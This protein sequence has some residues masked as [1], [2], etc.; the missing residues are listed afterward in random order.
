MKKTLLI[1]ACGVLALASIGC[2]SSTPMTERQEYYVGRSM[3]AETVNTTKVVT[4]RNVH[5]Y[6]NL[7][8]WNLAR[9]TDRPRTFKDYTVAV[10]KTN[11][12]N[13]Y[14]APSGFIF[15]TTGLILACETED[16][17]AAVMAHEI[18]H[19]VNKHPEK[20]VQT[21]KDREENAKGALSLLSTVGSAV[22]SAKGQSAEDIEF[23][24]Q[25]LDTVIDEVLTQIKHGYD[26]GQ[27]L[28][29]DAEGVRLMTEMGYDP[30]AMLTFLNRLKAEVEKDGGEGWSSDTHPHPEDRVEQVEDIIADE[31]LRGSIHPKR[32]ERF[33]EIQNILKAWLA[34]N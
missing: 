18:T 26:K 27:E 14:A 9:L 19:V 4:E 2:S 8:C 28:E 7:L 21:A 22:A 10:L 32:T 1:L 25:I 16:E 31:T 11:K 15:V 5:E 12:I 20:A 23:A 3:A 34:D 6:V 24:A 13:A 30:K 33:K 29:S 17:L